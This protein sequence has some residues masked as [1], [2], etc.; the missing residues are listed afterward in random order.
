M[1][2]DVR[3]NAVLDDASSTA[4]ALS[5]RLNMKC[6][7]HFLVQSMMLLL[8]RQIVMGARTAFDK[9]MKGVPCRHFDVR[10]Q[11]LHHAADRFAARHR[12]IRNETAHSLP[13]G[14]WPYPRSAH[15][16]PSS[17]CGEKNLLDPLVLHHEIP[18]TH[19]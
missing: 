9:T 5:G 13:V 15:P 7:L 12:G 14:A 11:R 4:N 8:L 17:L 19:P 1:S 2:L 10:N 3:S 16:A 6:L 18:M